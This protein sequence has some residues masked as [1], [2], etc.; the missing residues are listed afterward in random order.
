M[1]RKSSRVTIYDVAEQAGV[2]I[3][4]VSRV[5]NDSPDVAH[6][7]RERV[8]TTIN[9]LR[10]RPNR[11]AKALAHP[12]STVIAI[13]IPTFTT[14]FHNELLKGLRTVLADRDHDLL[15][16][17][18]GSANPLQK[19]RDTLK[20]GTVDGLILVGIPVDPPL[21]QELKACA[22]R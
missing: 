21:A 19:L 7:T 2:A 22:L 11:V 20:G 10:Y 5:L 9:E 18:L 13:A 17:D 15:L 3:S 12:R 6:Q 4:T 14:P 16:F 8:L 1:A